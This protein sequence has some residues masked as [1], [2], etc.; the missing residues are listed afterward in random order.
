MKVLDKGEEASYNIFMDS[1]ACCV[2]KESLKGIK[3]CNDNNIDPT[4]TSIEIGMSVGQIALDKVIELTKDMDRD[5]L[6]KWF[7]E[8]AVVN[9]VSR[10]HES[11][12]YRLKIGILS[13]IKK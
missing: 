7:T 12:T 2:F 11:P 6:L 5:T 10:M 9:V 1:I 8:I 3:E 13:G 4:K